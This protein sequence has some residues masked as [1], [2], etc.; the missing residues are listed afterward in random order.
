M[1]GLIGKLGIV[2][3]FVVVFLH[4]QHVHKCMLDLEPLEDMSDQG[5][6]ENVKWELVEEVVL[7]GQRF[8]S[9][10]LSVVIVINLVIDAIKKCAEMNENGNDDKRREKNVVNV[11][12]FLQPQDLHKMEPDLND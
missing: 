9:V 10:I 1:H 6:V 2:N 8:Y 3:F 7:Q 5:K 11:L 12:Q 4:V